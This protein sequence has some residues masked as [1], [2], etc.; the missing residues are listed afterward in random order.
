MRA[1]LS[2]LALATNFHESSGDVLD[3]AF[4]ENPRFHSVSMG[5]Y[6]NLSKYTSFNIAQNWQFVALPKMILNI[7]PEEILNILI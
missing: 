6:F 5:I 4:N 1:A 2:Q 3:L 7:I